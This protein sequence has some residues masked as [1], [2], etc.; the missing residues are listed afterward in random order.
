MRDK[1]YVIYAD[2]SEK[3]GRYYSNFFGGVLLEERDRDQIS[4]E[5]EAVKVDLGL[6]HEV[7]WQN[8]DQTCLD[9]Y[10][11][12]VRAFFTY[13]ATSRIKVRIMF[14]QNM[15]VPRSLQ[16]RHYDDQYFLLYYQFIKHAFGLKYA[17]HNPYQAVLVSVRPDKIP[18][19]KE[20]VD[21]FKDYLSRIPRSQLLRR[22][23]L[24]IPRNSIAEADSKDHVIMQ[25]LDL[26]L[27]SMCFRLNDKHKDIPAGKRWRGKRTL[28]KEALYKVI[29]QEIRKIY[30]NFN[31]GV[32][33]ACHYG[34]SDRWTHPYRHW[35][36]MPMSYVMDRNLG[37]RA[38][39]G[40]PT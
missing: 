36:F 3:K 25:G 31:I 39:P 27:G 38:A 32:G 30:P 10:A 21:R 29:S 6:L 28:A 12:F 2:E 16:K 5:L 11:E 18:D 14:T 35:L 23:N 34:P 4:R 7:K 1:H 8:V 37:K 17:D 15:R 26:V 19:T 24:H 40:R 22:E 13:V 33:T 9:R 20:R